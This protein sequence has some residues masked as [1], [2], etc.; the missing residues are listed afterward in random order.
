MPTGFLPS[1]L[2]T[3][4]FSVIVERESSAW[5]APRFSCTGGSNDQ[6][7]PIRRAFL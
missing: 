1:G 3:V 6:R 2:E 5:L 7:E 4:D